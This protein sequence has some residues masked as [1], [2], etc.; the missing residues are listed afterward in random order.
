M[1][2]KSTV[3]ETDLQAYVKK[4]ASFILSLSSIKPGIH[5]NYSTK[6]LSHHTTLEIKSVYLLW[7]I[8]TGTFF[9]EYTII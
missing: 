9:K 6:E 4:T 7:F 1:L 8:Q 5:G 2:N 3:Q